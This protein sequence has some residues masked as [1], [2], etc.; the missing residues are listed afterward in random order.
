MWR[1]LLVN[2]SDPSKAER[3]AVKY[4]RK[5]EQIRLCHMD[6]N[7][8]TLPICFQAAIANGSSILLLILDREIYIN[9]ELEACVSRLLSEVNSQ[10]EA[11]SK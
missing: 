9:K 8:L 5:K 2:S 3:I 11:G 6:L 10:T 7:I 4:I 1:S